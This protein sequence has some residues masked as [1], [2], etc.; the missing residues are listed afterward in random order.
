MF[1]IGLG[2]FC[3]GVGYTRN[4]HLHGIEKSKPSKIVSDY[5]S[6]YFSSKDY[7]IYAEKLDLG[8]GKLTIAVHLVNKDN[9]IFDRGLGFLEKEGKVTPYIYFERN[10]ILD[11]AGKPI[12]DVSKFNY[13]RVQ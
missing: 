8:D 10:K 9:Q 1:L 3:V 13:P 4:L 6:S 12:I 7:S 2:M 5:L 11:E